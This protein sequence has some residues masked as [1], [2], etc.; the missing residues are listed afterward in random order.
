MKKPPTQPLHLSR[1]LFIYF[2]LKKKKKKKKTFL[3]FYINLS[4]IPSLLIFLSN[5]NPL[6]S[7]TQNQKS[8]LTPNPTVTL[9]SLTTKNEVGPMISTTATTS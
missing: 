8:W 9:L 7:E 6:L 1:F 3:A 5:Q 4:F 2:S